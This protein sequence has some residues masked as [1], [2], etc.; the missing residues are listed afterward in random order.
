MTVMD[1]NSGQ[2]TTAS[3]DEVHNVR[4]VRISRA[5]ASGAVI[6]HRGIHTVAFNAVDAGMVVAL[7][8]QGDVLDHEGVR[9]GRIRSGR[10]DA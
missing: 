1:E 9:I 3:P 7:D 2:A 5:L 8:L 6:D 10:Y 4:G